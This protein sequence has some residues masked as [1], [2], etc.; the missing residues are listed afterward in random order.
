MAK[1]SAVFCSN[2]KSTT[3]ICA[4]AWLAF[5]TAVSAQDEEDNARTGFDTIVVTAQRVEQ[6]LQTTPVAV[7]ALQADDLEKRQIT[8][9]N[10]VQYNAPNVTVEPLNGN[11]GASVSIR[12]LAG[13]ENTSAS[14]PAVGIY[15]DGVYSARSSIGLLELVDV[16][17][18]EVLRGPQG[19]LF[20]RNTTG[21][22]INITTPTP[23][24]EFGGRL[25]GRYGNYDA[26][27]VLGHVNIPMVGEEF[28][29][30]VSFKHSEHDGYGESLVTGEELANLNSDYFRAVV[31][32]APDDANWS[33]TA[34]ADHY[35]R[36]GNN[37]IIALVAVR[38]DSPTNPSIADQFGFSNFI[39]TDFYSTFSGADNFD[40]ITAQGASVTGEITFGTTTIKSITAVRRLTNNINTDADGSP[41]PLLEFMQDN[42][43]KN[44]ITQE[45]QAYGTTGRFDWIVGGFFFTEDNDD[46][47]LSTT[48]QTIGE[49]RNKSYAIYGQGSFDLTDQLRLNAG[50]RYTWDERFAAISLLNAAGTVCVLMQTDAPGDCT[51]TRSVKYD[52]L[53]FNAGLDYQVSDDVFAYAKASRATRSGGFNHRTEAPAYEPEEVTSY[54]IGLKATTFN[55]RLRA[56][57]A[58]FWTQY[59]NVQRTAVRINP[60][61]MLPTAFT[62]NAAKAH[63][64]GVEL[65]LSALPTDNL[66]LGGT[67]GWLDPTYDEFTDITGDRSDEPFTY[68]AD[69]TYNLY[70]TYT[71]PLSFGE[72][73]LHA[74]WGYKGDIF[75]DTANPAVDLQEGYGILNLR[76][77]V[78]VENPNIEFAL[79]ARNVTDTE[80]NTYVLDV[81]NTPFGFAVNYR[82]TPR[83]W[84]G[85]ITL[86]F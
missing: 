43:Q 41:I 65:E 30:R 77:A 2:L 13:V 19:T 67:V 68:T 10:A 20:G 36:K 45:L 63:I 75:F 32:L 1:F 76:G 81:L 79:F 27:D 42:E 25:T 35:N 85:E 39:P 38:P 73:V 58:A 21:G 5:P 18:I 66:E 72:A 82:G 9:I 70:A 12:G 51:L 23:T 6:N 11:S 83:I 40:D 31:R 80:Y 46:V 69:F 71:A 74:D 22:A 24:G 26:W 29:A 48:A 37:Q 59:N 7:T 61:T 53:S 28:A 49:I 4:A 57:I 84:G 47:T 55:N 54:E 15:I 64:P 50:L 56:N 8:D 62:T 16:E 3:A 14:D 44:Q 78:R 34:N 52:Y 60:A 33:L 17:R 86:R